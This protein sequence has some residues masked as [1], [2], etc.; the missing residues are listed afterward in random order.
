MKA[1]I[2]SILSLVAIVKALPFG[3]SNKVATR[4]SDAMAQEHP[5]ADLD[6]GEVRVLDYP[7]KWNRDENTIQE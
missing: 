5:V 3:E 7:V 4:G 2:I 6:E 1:Q